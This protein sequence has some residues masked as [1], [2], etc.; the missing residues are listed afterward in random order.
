MLTNTGH[1]LLL[2]SIM[3][4]LPSAVTH[5]SFGI[6]YLDGLDTV[7]SIDELYRR[8]S[9][10]FEVIRV[11]IQTAYDHLT[12]VDPAADKREDYQLVYK[13]ELPINRR[14]AFNEIGL[15][16]GSAN[17][18]YGNNDSKLISTCDVSSGWKKVTIFEGDNLTPDIEE[19]LK[20]TDYFNAVREEYYVNSV[21]K[22]AQP[23]VE[24]TSI[25]LG[26]PENNGAY[27]IYYNY[28]LPLSLDLS[29]YEPEDVL[30]IAF[31]WVPDIRTD[32]T[33]TTTTTTTTL[34]HKVMVEFGFK[35]ISPIVKELTF[36]TVWSGNSN[37]MKSYVVQ[38]IPLAELVNIANGRLQYI[39]LKSNFTGSTPPTAFNGLLLDGIRLDRAHANNPL[40][41]LVF[42]DRVF[43]EIMSDGSQYKIPIEKL[44]GFDGHI[45]H[46]VRLFANATGE[47]TV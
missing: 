10:G 30:K 15:W 1:G 43:D 6:N 5:M 18:R 27:Y 4:T 45:E 24:T 42:Y 37:E 32:Q 11:P 35:N 3:G 13:G 14:L 34:S 47:P 12:P 25:I 44:S 28:K 20:Q 16:Q 7:G 2:R 17:S 9:L 40:Y 36:N 21:F 39:A 22:L 46:R 19:L 31:A 41:G 26:F 8:E 38:Y 23:R 33:F 29:L